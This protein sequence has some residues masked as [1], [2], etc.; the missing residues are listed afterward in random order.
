MTGGGARYFGRIPG[1]EIKK[2]CNKKTRPGSKGRNKK[3]QG[4]YS[5]LIN[6]LNAVFFQ[7]SI[8]FYKFQ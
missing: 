8:N 7:K 2:G 3:T 1:G 4:P 5:A 6:Y